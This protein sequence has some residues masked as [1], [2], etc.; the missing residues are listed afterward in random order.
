ML[1]LRWKIFV[2]L[3]IIAVTITCKREPLNPLDPNNPYTLGK[4]YICQAESI[5]IGRIKLSWTKIDQPQ[6]KGYRIFRYKP[7]ENPVAI[8]DIDTNLFFDSQLEPGQTYI[9]YYRLL[10]EDNREIHKSPEDAVKTFDS[11][12]GFTIK[13]V[14][15]TRIELKWDDLNWLD[16]YSYCRIF[17]RQNGDF[18][19]Y[20][21]TSSSIEYVDTHVQENVTYRFKLIAVANDGATSNFTNETYATPG[22]N[23]PRIDSIRPPHP[24]AIWGHS[25]TITCYAYDHDG[26]SIHYYWE[27]LDGGEITGSGQTIEFI[28]PQDTLLTHRVEVR[29]SDDYGQGDM[30]T[31]NVLSGIRVTIDN[32]ANSENLTDYQVKVTLTPSNFDYSLVARPDGGDIRFFTTDGNQL[33]Y[34]IENWS[35]G[36]TSK[37]WIKIPSI[38]A[39]GRTEIYL[40]P[41]G[42]INAPNLSEGDSTFDWFKDVW[43]STEV[44]VDKS[45]DDW[46]YLQKSGDIVGL[47]LTGEMES[48]FLTKKVIP[49]YT[50]T[51]ELVVNYKIKF[52]YRNISDATVNIIFNVP[53]TT[54][55]W[56]N[57]PIDGHPGYLNSPVAENYL[58]SFGTIPEWSGTRGISNSVGGDELP[59]RSA[60]CPQNGEWVGIDIKLLSDRV[61]TESKGEL[62]YSR[63]ETTFHNVT[64][65]TSMTPAFGDQTT[66]RVEVDRIFVR[67]YTSPEPVITLGNRFGLDLMKAK[68]WV[69]R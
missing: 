6:I 37:I 8:A 52:T 31:A 57:D 43:D 55:P 4:D 62:G 7:N 50:G 25:V 39:N 63:A 14:T 15:R 28:V 38:P 53:G 67:K 33:P 35:S 22:N 13:D 2:L 24:V 44:S 56:W 69:E 19:L 26:D 29:V 61:I 47:E 9:Y 58:C 20:D 30:V 5:G 11:P 40:G 12:S 51:Q 45:G 64:Q 68:R 34:W 17:R 21:S 46:A 36:G 42:N 66:T 49:L 23:V 54:H 10:W 41:L 18:V 27:A 3:A 16:N 32:T 65:Y 60:P 59:S 48:I 1:T